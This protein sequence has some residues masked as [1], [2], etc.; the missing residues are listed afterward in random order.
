MDDFVPDVVGQ[1]G[2]RSRRDLVLEAGVKVLEEV[3]IVRDL[4]PLRV[5]ELGREVSH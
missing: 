2:E 5:L 1:L 4:V 3:K